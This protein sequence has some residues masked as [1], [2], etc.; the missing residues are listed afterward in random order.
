[1]LKVVFSAGT[2]MERPFGRVML[3]S[4]RLLSARVHSRRTMPGPLLLMGNAA[5]LITLKYR[6]QVSC[7]LC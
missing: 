6:N 3:A 2:S 7:F 4:P 5:M 1:M